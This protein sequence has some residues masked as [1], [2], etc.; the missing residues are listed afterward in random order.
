MTTRAH[1]FYK[2]QH[3]FNGELRIKV[4]RHIYPNTD[5]ELIQDLAQRVLEGQTVAGVKVEKFEVR[6]KNIT[7]ELS[8]GEYGFASD[9]IRDAE[10]QTEVEQKSNRKKGK[11]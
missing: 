7:E 11:K 6:G 10:P 2:K 9:F 5:A 4:N 8:N 1:N 3:A